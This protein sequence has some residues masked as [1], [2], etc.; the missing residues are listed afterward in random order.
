DVRSSA[1]GLFNVLILGL[2]PVFATFA[3]L[4]LKATYTTDGKLDYPA[5]FQ[6]S[7]WAAIIGALILFIFFHPRKVAEDPGFSRA[8]ADAPPAP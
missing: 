8:E 1:Q 3:C 2:G 6:Y 5:V 4:Q 7:M